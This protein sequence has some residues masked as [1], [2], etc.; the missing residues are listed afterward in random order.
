[1]K[2]KAVDSKWL[3][4]IIAIATPL[5]GF[6]LYLARYH[7]GISQISIPSSAWNDEFFYYK[8][9]EAMVHYGIPKGYFGYNESRAIIGNLGGW[10]IAML[11]PFAAI[12]KLFG[13]T[14]ITPVVI[15]VILWI[16]GFVYF[17]VCL[18]PTVRQQVLVSFVWL[19]YSINIRYIFS[20]APE[21]LIVVLLFI[22]AVSFVRF[23][24]DTNQLKWLVIADVSLFYL[25]LIRGYYILFVLLILS[26]VFQ[27]EKRLNKTI[28]IQIVVA[29]LAVVG[30]VLIV[31]YGIAQYFTPDVS[32]D[33]LTNPKV[34]IKNNILGMLESFQYIGQA[35]VLKSMRGSWYIIYYLLL[36]YMIYK[37]I[38]TKDFVNYAIL[39]SWFVLLIAM[40]T[41]YNAQEGCRHLMACSLVYLMLL[42]Y[43]DV[44]QVTSCIYIAIM[45]YSTWL[46]Q[47]D[48]FSPI[49]PVNEVQM[50]TIAQGK[51]ALVQLMPLSDDGWDNTVI[52]TRSAVFNDLYAIPAGF[53]INCCLDGYVQ[54]NFDVLNSKYIAAKAESEIDDFLAERCELI[55]KYGQTNIYKIR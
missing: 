28:V 1:M 13:W 24:K 27:E 9:I 26:T 18:K 43:A 7:V 20:A 29:L 53:G 55:I 42:A 12:G 47:E 31:H 8:Q 19:A 52:Y 36:P 5:L 21:S 22:F 34:L 50:Q 16:C 33:W 45:V 51:E 15:N 41:I 35:L 38:K 40:W 48:F 30:Y 46:S 39:I 23:N 37:C 2:Q 14:Y 3:V 17:A 44:R 32:T 11:L 4:L 54:E 25:T 6:I 49:L 10:S